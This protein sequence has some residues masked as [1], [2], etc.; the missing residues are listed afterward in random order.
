MPVKYSVLLNVGKRYLSVIHFR[1]HMGSRE[2]NGHIFRIG[3]QLAHM[4]LLLKVFS[5]TF[6]LDPGLLPHTRHKWHKKVAK[7]LLTFPTFDQLI[8]KPL[9]HFN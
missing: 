4:E 3:D 5:I 8:I 9:L 7:Q 1:L 6:L 2:L